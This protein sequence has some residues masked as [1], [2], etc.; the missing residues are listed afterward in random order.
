V[1]KNENA[2]VRTKSDF[3]L[4][5]ADG[6]DQRR[7]TYFNV[8][9]HPEYIPTGATCADSAWGK[10][11]RHVAAYMILDVKGMVGQIVM[12]ELRNIQ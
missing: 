11:G 7:L 8:P 1:P 3:W 6:S 4:M 9:G 10:D 12:I 2:L 5:G